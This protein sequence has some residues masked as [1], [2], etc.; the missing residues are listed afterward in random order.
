MIRVT[1]YGTR[2]I[3]REGYSPV[4]SLREIP[5]VLA[6]ILPTMERDLDAYFDRNFP[7]IIEEWGLVSTVHLEEIERRIERVHRQIDSLEKSRE[8]LESRAAALEKEIRR[9][10]GQ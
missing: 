3:P 8:I 5:A 6:D 2:V 10:E 4:E 9:L 1:G 7:A